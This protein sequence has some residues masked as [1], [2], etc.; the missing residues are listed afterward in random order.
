MPAS[1][2]REQAMA[3]ALVY[4]AGQEQVRSFN[5]VVKGRQQHVHGFERQAPIPVSPDVA[6]GRWISPAKWAEGQQEWKDRQRLAEERGDRDAMLEKAAAGERA[7]AFQQAAEGI[8]RAAQMA[9]EDFQ[10]RFRENA[11]KMA[12]IENKHPQTDERWR[13]LVPVHN[14]AQRG[15]EAEA[16]DGAHRVTGK[17][18]A[19]VG[20]AGHDHDHAVIDS[21]DTGMR[22][23]VQLP[24]GDV[25]KA[26]PLVDLISQVR[27]D[28]V[29]WATNMAA[30]LPSGLRE[31]G[32]TPGKPLAEL[33]EG[34]PVGSR[35]PMARKLA[36]EVAE[37]LR[38]HLDPLQPSGGTQGVVQVVDL[39]DGGKVVVKEAE[40]APE[41]DR[42][43]LASY[44]AQAIGV[45]A[46]VAVEESD[47]SGIV[48]E[49]IPG[50]TLGRWLVDGGNRREI[51]DRGKLIGLLDWMVAN[52]DRNMANSIIEPDGTP[53]AIDHGLASFSLYDALDNGY[54]D[55]YLRDPLPDEQV[56][57]IATRLAAIQPEF[58]RMSR[59]DWYLNSLAQLA[60]VRS[61]PPDWQDPAWA[62]LAQLIIDSPYGGFKDPDEY[63]NRNLPMGHWPDDWRPQ[64]AEKRPE[65]RP[66]FG[67]PETGPGE[68]KWEFLNRFG[69]RALRPQ[70]GGLARINLGGWLR[71]TVRAIIG[72]PSPPWDQ[73]AVIDSHNGMRYLARVPDGHIVNLEAMSAM[74]VG[75]ADDPAKWG[76]LYL[77]GMR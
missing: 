44:V 21:T 3:A 49:F 51:F 28:P 4:L 23:L 38:G 57:K 31:F 5:R 15:A 35:S 33:P 73:Y 52:T 30:M 60:R 10:R 36:A 68:T 61:E 70:I 16:W 50:K 39:D 58:A 76:R 12:S 34:P 53:V 62:P 48:M 41:Q 64:G 1:L 8:D 75:L 77:G 32:R 37:G 72:M 7:A 66:P 24:D 6:A 55:A 29:G 9:E 18:M 42:E 46:P 19:V 20:S 2:T 14:D 40:T 59:Q 11:E 63:P 69:D 27:D 25:E 65:I 13:F 54:W 56:D 45:K 26:V 67:P 47:G 71:G 17:V 74:P 22:Y 43:V